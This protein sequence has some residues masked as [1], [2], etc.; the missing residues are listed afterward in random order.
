M[1]DPGLAPA[2]DLGSLGGKPE[3]E[4]VEATILFADLRGFTGLAEGREPVDV[5]DL[6]NQCFPP[7]IGCI[8][9][10][11]GT[12]DKFL[13]DGIMAV[14]GVNGD[15]GDHAERAVRAGL[16]M[17]DVMRSL[18]PGLQLAGWESVGLGV[19]LET[20]RVVAGYVGLPARREFTVLGDVVNVASRLTAGA[21]A[22]EVV[23]GPGAGEA[24][25]ERHP[26]VPLGTI[27]IRGRR[28]PVTAWRV[29]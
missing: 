5:L 20:G 10:E 3:A 26:L 2:P 8:Q 19:G 9:A 21:A 7:L 24:V 15:Q 18:T 27:S 23:L 28:A 12:L 25:Q 16:A 1:I 4:E 11:G 13:G 22:G 29:E 17:Q 6:I 14:F